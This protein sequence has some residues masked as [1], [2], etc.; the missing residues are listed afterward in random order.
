MLQLFGPLS[1][2]PFATSPPTYSTWQSLDSFL[3]EYC[4]QWT[5]WVEGGF[6][7]TMPLKKRAP[8]PNKQ[9]TLDIEFLRRIP[10]SE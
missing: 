5:G 4:R 3:L 10:C 6:L 1:S 8:L 9:G 7:V 2:P